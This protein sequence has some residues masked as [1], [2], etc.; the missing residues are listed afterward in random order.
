MFEIAGETRL[1]RLENSSFQALVSVF[2]GRMHFSSKKLPLKSLRE[3][4]N[5]VFSVLRHE[6]FKS[7]TCFLSGR[8]EQAEAPQYRKKLNQSTETMISSRLINMVST[9]CS[10]SQ[11]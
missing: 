9:A 2:G 6:V 7:H 10:D 1:L 4:H 11:A 8:Q 5:T 3:T